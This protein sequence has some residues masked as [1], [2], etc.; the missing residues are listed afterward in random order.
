MITALQDSL[1]V[2]ST[3]KLVKSQL[4]REGFDVGVIVD[5]LYILDNK[6]QTFRRLMPDMYKAVCEGTWKL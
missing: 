6:T 5:P 4:M 1:E 3:F 2:T